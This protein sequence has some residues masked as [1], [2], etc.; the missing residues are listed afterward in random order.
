MTLVDET[1]SLIEA[2]G[3]FFTCRRHIAREGSVL[4]AM[5]GSRDDAAEA[6]YRLSL[7]LSRRQ[8]GRSWELRTAVDLAEV[9]S[10]R[11]KYAEATSVLRPVY[12]Q[13]TEGW[14]TADLMA[15]KCLPARLEQG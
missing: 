11:G 15:A 1:I 14:D 12:G 6:S 9:L 10:A 5:P 13:F 4:L 7:E 2:N 3:D 8:D